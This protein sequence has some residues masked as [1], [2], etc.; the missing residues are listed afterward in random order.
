MWNTFLLL[1]L[2]WKR[3]Q[4]NVIRYSSKPNF[5]IRFLF[6]SIAFLFNYPQISKFDFNEILTCAGDFTIDRIQR[7]EQRIVFMT[8]FTDDPLGLSFSGI[9]SFTSFVAEWTYGV[10]NPLEG[11][12]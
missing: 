9:D 1:L 7:L 10:L 5:K 6:H 12:T 4:K 11:A 3:I 8:I 2:L